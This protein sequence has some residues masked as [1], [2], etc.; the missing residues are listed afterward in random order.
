M[1]LISLARQIT[2]LCL[3]THIARKMF[4][5]SSECTAFVN[6]VD[7]L[8]CVACLERREVGSNEVVDGD[9]K[10]AAATEYGS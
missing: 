8:S 1:A 10:G 4:C 7:N 5:I 9:K 6:G 3:G 2:F